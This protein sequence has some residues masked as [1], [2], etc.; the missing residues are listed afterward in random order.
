MDRTLVMSSPNVCSNTNG[1]NLM[2]RKHSTMANNIYYPTSCVSKASQ[3]HRKTQIE[4][5]LLRSQQSILNHHYKCIEGRPTFQEC[6][7]KYV[8][9]AAHAIPSFD[10]ESHASSPKNILDP[11]KKFLV[12]LYWFCNPHSMIGRTL[13]ATSGCL[14]AVEKL[15]DIS[16]LFFIGLLQV[17]IPNFFMDIYVNGVNQLFDLEIDKINKPFLPLVSGN[18]SITNAVFI[19]ASSAILSFWLSLIIGSWSLIWNVALCFLL[20]TA[21]SV[22]TFVF[23]RP[24]VFTRSLIVSM[25]FYGFY[26]ISLAL[27][28]DIPDIEGD[29]KFG[30]RSFATR[31]VAFGV[32]LLAGASSSSPLWIKIITG[33]GSIIPATILWYQ[34]KYVDLS[35]PDSTRSFYMLNWKVILLKS[36]Y[37]LRS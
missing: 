3:C 26:S 15:S 35:S 8:V 6:N 36:V 5:N 10:S 28:K 37:H 4:C 33:L 19:V 11:V 12:A 7:R 34:T 32:V 20:W 25:V 31:L 23:K 24:V 17:L 30:I 14:L 2:R 13:S 18:L 21:Y 9:K 16:P 29:T 27:S 1:G 22:N